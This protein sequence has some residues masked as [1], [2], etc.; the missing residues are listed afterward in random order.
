MRVVWIMFLRVLCRVWVRLNVFQGGAMVSLA[1]QLCNNSSL[2]PTQ[3]Q[4]SHSRQP[5]PQSRSFSYVSMFICK[6]PGPTSVVYA[7]MLPPLEVLD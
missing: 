7:T 6:F 1:A 4:S 5:F 3:I 2:D